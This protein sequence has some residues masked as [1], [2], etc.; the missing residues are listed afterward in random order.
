MK[1][2]K[3]AEDKGKELSFREVMGKGGIGKLFYIKTPEE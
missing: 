2:Q 1:W 3:E